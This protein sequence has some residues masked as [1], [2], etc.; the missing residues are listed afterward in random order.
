MAKTTKQSVTEIEDL[1]T[2]EIIQR[3]ERLMRLR[4]A[5][6]VKEALL[7]Q[8]W[9]KRHEYLFDHFG[10]NDWAV[11]LSKFKG[12]SEW[13][14]ECERPFGEHKP[15]YEKTRIAFLIEFRLRK[16][17]CPKRPSELF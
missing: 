16:I 8:P 4:Q 6:R 12:G 3:D 5:T 17:A 9:Q 7:G 13:C 2:A 14:N 10:P 1:L 11:F 15:E